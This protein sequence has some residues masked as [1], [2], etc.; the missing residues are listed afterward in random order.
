MAA[1]ITDS[2]RR[3]TSGL[4]ARRNAQGFWEGRVASSPLAT[5]VAVCALADEAGANA[6]LSQASAYLARTQNPDGGWGDTELSQSNLAATLLVLSADALRQGR[7]RHPADR[8]ALTG[9]QHDKARAFTARLGG[10]E[11]GLRRA[12][13]RDLTFQVPIRMT[14]AGAGLLPWSQVDALP[15]ELALAPRRLMGALRLPVVSYALPALVCVGLSRHGKAPSWLLPVRW[16]RAAV[17]DRALELILKMQPASGGY[18]EAVPITAFCLL[19]LKAADRGDHRIALNA[20]KFLLNTQREDG[21]WPVEVHLSVWNTT[22]AVDALAA[23]GLLESA[24]SLEERNKTRDWLLAQQT[25]GVSVYSDA[26]PGGWG[27]NHLSGSVP[28]ADDTAGALIA[29]RRLGVT[30]DHAACLA[31]KDW[32]LALQNRDGGWPTFCRGWN[33]LPFDK[34]APDLTAHAI[35]ALGRL[36]SL[37]PEPRVPPPLAGGGRGRAICDALNAGWNYLERVQRPDGSFT[38]LWFGCEA[39]PGHANGAYGTSK[40][41]Y[42]CRSFRKA[43]GIQ[44]RAL[45]WLLSVQNPDGGFGGCAGARSTAEETGLAL[46]ALVA[47]GVD[48][49]EACCARAAQ[50]LLERQ[51]ADGSWDPAPIG[52]YF[53]VL[54]Y[55][56]ELY[57]LCY[58][59]GGLGAWARVEAG[60]EP[61]MNA[62]E[63]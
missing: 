24:L 47:G 17:A 4:L 59:L 11:A 56:E 52:F 31:G 12:Y 46:R 37:E 63:R 45:K 20:R 1:G 41:L 60:S 29:L 61:Q 19:G 33:K 36:R 35:R 38:P 49:K 18:L 50:W 42:A 16:L 21:S 58:A 8:V 14:A 15:F 7:S 5:A 25:Q 28:D 30:E 2:L 39:A 22:R 3:A 10:L 27:W 40:V 51:R 48:P 13:G 32:L 62:G 57:P 9:E 44:E 43:G 23:A 55:Y 54:W 53:A 34:S 26:K 6:R